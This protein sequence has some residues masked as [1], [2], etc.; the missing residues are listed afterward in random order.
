VKARDYQL[1]AVAAVRKYFRDGNYYA[2]IQAPTGSGK[3]FIAVEFIRQML[4]TYSKYRVCIIIPK[5]AIIES[6]VKTL[7]TVVPHITVTVAATSSHGKNLDGQ[8][9]VGSY[10]TLYRSKQLPIFDLVICD[11]AHRINERDENSQYYYLLKTIMASGYT[12]CLALTATPFRDVGYIYGPGKL[13]KE[14]VFKRDL[15]WTTEMGFTVKATLWSSREHSFD[16]TKLTVDNTGEYSTSELTELTANEEKA[17]AQ[18]SDIIFCTTSRKKI[19]I[20]CANIKHAELIKKLL[21]EHNEGKT[22]IVHSNQ[23]WEEREISLGAFVTDPEVRFLVFIS[24]VAEGFDC[25]DRETEI[26]TP[27]GWVGLDTIGAE[28]ECYS[29]NPKTR[30]LEI[31]PIERSFSRLA[32]EKMVTIKSQHQDIRVTENHNFAFTRTHGRNRELLNGLMLAPVSR[33]P[34]RPVFFLNGVPPVTQNGCG[35]GPINAWVLGMVWTDGWSNGDTIQI[36]QCK[37]HT[38]KK[39]RQ[40][41]KQSSFDFTECIKDV[42]SNWKQNYKKLHTFNIPK[43]TGN[44]SRKRRGFL[45]LFGPSPK[46]PNKK[47]LNMSREEFL[48]F[49]EG[50]QD[51]NGSHGGRENVRV[52]LC[53]KAQVDF[54]MHL[55]TKLGFSSMYGSYKTKNDVDVY[56]LSVRKKIT[57]GLALQ[58]KRG[59]VVKITKPENG[60]RVWC[61]SNKNGTVISRRNGKI[62]VIGN[63]PQIDTIVLLRPTRRANLFIQIVGRALRPFPGKQDALVLDYGNV[64]KNCGPLNAPFVNTKGGK[65]G[66]EDAQALSDVAVVQCL[67]CGAFFFPIKKD[68]KEGV[69]P[70]CPHCLSFH[71]QKAIDPSKRLEKKTATD[72]ALYGDIVKKKKRVSR[73][74][75]DLTLTHVNY[76]PLGY[77]AMEKSKRKLISFYFKEFPRREFKIL[78]VNPLFRGDVDLDKWQ[79]DKCAELEPGLQKL[80]SDV[81]GDKFDL[82]SIRSKEHLIPAKEIVMTASIQSEPGPPDWLTYK[83]HKVIL[84]ATPK[85]TPE[86]VA[87]DAPFF[88][89]EL[90]LF[91]DTL[92]VGYITSNGEDA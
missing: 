57:H 80:M 39:I 84:R 70:Q 85:A 68:L 22:E 81:V 23:D 6:F 19:A 86:P 8:I 54:V 25:L 18:V 5:L 27:N 76:L 51:G 10:Q 45:N 58:D 24:I 63:C 31:V 65:R 50:M 74:T 83:S 40:K 2:L 59:A 69:N 26:L 35:L 46:H 7:T 28:K 77:D 11:E 61:V 56:N 75:M 34:A 42:T 9:V 62:V 55:A 44:G 36:F 78:F 53:N 3:S 89:E 49:W 48:S 30:A 1:E 92:P 52:T 37:P 71:T 21:D 90:S 66:L 43:G 29:V 33:L 82:Y 17:R 60:E 91:D 4:E 79:L 14:L 72:V 12:R 15:L 38:V 67:T 73:E 32:I 16:T 64:I 87:D 13:F 88:G 41:L 20:A 47:L